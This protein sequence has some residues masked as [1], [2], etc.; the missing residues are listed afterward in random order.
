MGLG[1]RYGVPS[2]VVRTAGPAPMSLLTVPGVLIP[3]TSAQW[4]RGVLNGVAVDQDECHRDLAWNAG[5]SD[6]PYWW[7]IHQGA[8]PTQTA[9]ETAL[10]TTPAAGDG[11][12]RVSTGEGSDDFDPITIWAGDTCRAGAEDLEAEARARALANLEA[13]TATAIER[14][15]WTAQVANLAG[16]NNPAFIDTGLATKVQNGSPLGFVTALGELEQAVADNANMTGRVLIHAQPRVITVWQSRGLLREAPGAT[17]LV[18]ANGSI[19]I[20]ERGATGAG[21]TGSGGANATYSYSWA[22][23][24]GMVRVWLGNPVALDGLVRTTNDFEARAERAFVA[25]W[26]PCGLLAVRV[27][28]CDEYCIGAS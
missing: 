15:L 18:T 25:A 27:A 11:T 28:L 19:V 12:K 20:P 21:P 2:G 26:N 3:P 8:T 22:Y 10:E 23:A 5:E 24:T 7:D 16:F 17:H 9:P 13:I 14:E 6:F 4:S 1:P